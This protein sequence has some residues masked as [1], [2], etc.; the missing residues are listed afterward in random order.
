LQVLG[1]VRDAF[2]K[3][4]DEFISVMLYEIDTAYTDS[5]IY[6]K[7]PSYITNTQDSTVIFKLDY[8]KEG[9]YALF[10]MKD[11]AKN[12]LFDQNADKIAFLK[13]T[14]S[15]PTDSTYVLTL[16]KEIGNYRASV[17]NFAAKNKIVFGYYG[18]E[19][20]IEIKP[21]SSI[22]DTVKTKIL[23]DG[24][25][26]TLNFW[27]TPYKTDSLIFEVTNKKNMV[28]DTFIV[29]SRRVG[30]DSLT[31]QPNQNGSLDYNVPYYL[32][33]NTP[34][35]NFDTS[36]ISMAVM[37]S[38]PLDFKV[39]FDSIANTLGFD[40]N[41]EPNE[42]YTLDLF[43]GAI[44]D[45]F[46]QTNDTINYRL[47]TRSYSDLGDLALNIEGDF[48]YPILVQLTDTDGKTLLELFA[49]EKQPFEFSKI[50]PASYLIRVVQDT[51]GNGKWDTGNF[52]KKQ[53]PEKIS[54]Y[55]NEI[56][57]RANWIENITFTIT[58]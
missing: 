53:Q 10:A 51:N 16:F 40:F 12:N 52:L 41:M 30:I 44:T 13:D 39:D 38:I 28:V 49:E 22:P 9:D 56:Q 55:P 50:Q 1:V 29:K 8:L 54:Y 45:L 32:A 20:D 23:R 15:L 33:I 34:V 58:N 21:L 57:M 48:E 42:N 6:K 46:G 17:P 4:V 26:D 36:K 3:Q 2:K 27:F 43:P 31:I 35:V 5:T 19:E 24:D 47:S 7:P 37:D 18:G 25:K 14:I 11:E